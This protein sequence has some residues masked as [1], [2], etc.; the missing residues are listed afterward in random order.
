[1]HYLVVPLL[2]DDVFST[3]NWLPHLP[4]YIWP[5]LRDPQGKEEPRLQEVDY[6]YI[7][8]MFT[9]IPWRYLEAMVDYFLDYLSRTKPLL[10]QN[11]V[12]YFMSQYYMLCARW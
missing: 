2:G 5:C 4:I 8:D 12:C 10:D 6:F 1:M 9:A 7:Y 3:E 11:K